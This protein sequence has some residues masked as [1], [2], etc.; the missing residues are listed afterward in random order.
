MFISSCCQLFRYD[1]QLFVY[2][3]TGEG[4]DDAGGVFDDTMSEMCHEI[5]N[6]KSGLNLLVL[7]PNGKDET[8]LNRDKFLLNCDHLTPQKCHFFRFL[9][10]LIGVAIRTNKPIAI[11][12]A[13]MVWKLLSLSYIS[14]EDIEEVDYLYAKSLQNLENIEENSGIMTES[15][16]KEVIP[17][18]TF[19]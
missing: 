1:I 15:A 6:L 13:P 11:N 8:G 4:A 12:L 10:I 19:E 7:T 16:F 5:S 9:G 17:Q 3:F 18:E 2:Y 14:R